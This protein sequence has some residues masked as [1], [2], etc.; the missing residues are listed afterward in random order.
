MKSSSSIWTA[1][2]ISMNKEGENRFCFCIFEPEFQTNDQVSTKY[3]N[4]TVLEF[5]NDMYTVQ[6]KH[7]IVF[8]STDE[9]SPP[10]V[11]ILA[12]FPHKIT[13]FVKY[14]R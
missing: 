3:G 11:P 12:F 1:E 6:V 14:I 10:L 8:I 5:E 13:L 9:I 4:G 2:N 7:G